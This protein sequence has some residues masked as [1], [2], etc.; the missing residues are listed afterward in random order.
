ME[1]H[2][3]QEGVYSERAQ[4]GTTIKIYLS[5]LHTQSKVPEW[6]KAAASLITAFTSWSI[7]KLVAEL[8]VKYVYA[9]RGYFAIG[10]EYILMAAVFAG[11]F[12][13][14]NRFFKIYR[15]NDERENKRK[16]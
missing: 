9:E 2:D 11:S 14:I 13:I 4:D 7:T 1:M 10:S 16:H 12:Y 8:L 3:M 15:G 5:G 6:Q